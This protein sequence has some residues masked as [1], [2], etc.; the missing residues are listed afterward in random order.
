VEEE[1]HAIVLHSY[2]SNLFKVPYHTESDFYFHFSW[3]RVSTTRRMDKTPKSVSSSCNN[4]GKFPLESCYL[5]SLL[6]LLFF[7]FW[8]MGDD[9]LNLQFLTVIFR[10]SARS[11]RDGESVV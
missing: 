10:W 1:P 11:N 6:S 9:G 7:S 4:D 3:F 2:R 8:G 5:L